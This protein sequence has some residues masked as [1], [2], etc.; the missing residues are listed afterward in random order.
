MR[1]YWKSKIQTFPFDTTLVDA[2][3][4][5]MPDEIPNQNFAVSRNKTKT[6]QSFLDTFLTCFLCWYFSC[7][8]TV[9]VFPVCQ[10]NLDL[11]YI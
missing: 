2:F 5:R 1:F 7:L 4:I 11:I 6:E 3:L 8:L 10:L 9:Y